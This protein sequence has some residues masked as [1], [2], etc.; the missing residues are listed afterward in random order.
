MHLILMNGIP[1]SGKS[2]IADMLS[3]RRYMVICRDDIRLAL[4]LEWENDVQQGRST[5]ILEPFVTATAR[6]MVVAYMNRKLPIVLD[7]TSLNVERI[8]EWARVAQIFG[9]RT[10]LLRVDTDVEECK[11]RRVP[12]GFPEGVIDAMATDNNLLTQS[13]EAGWLEGIDHVVYIKGE[14]DHV[15]LTNDLLK[16]RMHVNP[17]TGGTP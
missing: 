5:F 17:S 1:G 13:I 15:F 8:H 12:D 4:G 9:Y 6:T 11:K 10:T 2:W 16:V 3:R 7:E 14:G